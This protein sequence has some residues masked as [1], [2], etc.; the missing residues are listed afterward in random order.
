MTSTKPVI[1]ASRM[2][3]RLLRGTTGARDMIVRPDR[4]SRRELKV[5]FAADLLKATR[6][7]TSHSTKPE[8]NSKA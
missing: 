2:A 4:L 5:L 7:I 6:D 1:S 8:T 3:L